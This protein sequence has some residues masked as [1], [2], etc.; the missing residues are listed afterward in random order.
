MKTN[1]CIVIKWRRNIKQ[2]VNEPGRTFSEV[3]IPRNSICSEVRGQRSGHPETLFATGLPIGSP[4]FG[5]KSCDPLL[6]EKHNRYALNIGIVRPGLGSVV[7]MRNYQRVQGGSQGVTRR[8]AHTLGQACSLLKSPGGSCLDP[9][10]SDRAQNLGRVKCHLFA[11]ILVLTL[12]ELYH[13]P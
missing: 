1:Q 8:S 5:I 12:L 13:T 9:V 7:G 4:R 3:R 6:L 2:V 11:F 10:L